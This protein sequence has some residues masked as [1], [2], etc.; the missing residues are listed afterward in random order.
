MV[1]RIHLVKEVGYPSGPL[2]SHSQTCWVLELRC[3]LSLETFVGRS[4]GTG[5]LNFS[6]GVS[7]GE[8]HESLPDPDFVSGR[9][10]IGP[11]QVQEG[12]PRV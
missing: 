11:H 1:G 9:L 10:C 7:V 2:L 5:L 3:L 4:W 8:L 12:E 6:D